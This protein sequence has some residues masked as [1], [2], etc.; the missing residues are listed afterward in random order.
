MI[1]LQIAF[2]KFAQNFAGCD[3][4]TLVDMVIMLKW[5]LARSVDQNGD[6]CSIFTIRFQ[7]ASTCKWN[8]KSR[9]QVSAN[10]EGNAEDSLSWYPTDGSTNLWKTG[11]NIAFYYWRYVSRTMGYVFP[12]AEMPVNL[13]FHH[14]HLVVPMQ[15]RFLMNNSK[16][17]CT[18][19]FVRSWV[20]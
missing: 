5:K 18:E 11:E 12:F 15:S 19:T 9:E 8:E 3:I 13:Y 2:V 17:N 20:W 10:D 6:K 16:G 7:L 14:I 4:A 1:C